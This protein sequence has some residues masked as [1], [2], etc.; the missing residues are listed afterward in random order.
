MCL[1]HQRL[2]DTRET[3][4]KKKSGNKRRLE[5]ERILLLTE[6]SFHDMNCSRVHRVSVRRGML[7][8]T[9]TTGIV[10]DLFRPLLVFA[11]ISSNPDIKS[12]KIHG[13]KTKKSIVK[14]RRTSQED[15]DE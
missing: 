1:L 10:E 3:S 12:G 15:E 7:H 9:V 2:N 4:R 6:A 14:K 13:N 5:A 11:C 8:K